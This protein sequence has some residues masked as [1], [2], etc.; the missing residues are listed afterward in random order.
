M[1]KI[2]AADSISPCKH[3]MPFR[4]SSS[5]KRDAIDQDAGELV[6]RERTRRTAC[7]LS[8]RFPSLGD[9]PGAEGRALAVLRP[10][11]G[12]RP[13]RLRCGWHRRRWATTAGLSAVVPTPS[14]SSACG[15]LQRAGTHNWLTVIDQSH[16]FV[17]L[18]ENVPVRSSAAPPTSRPRGLCAGRRSRPNS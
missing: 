16:H 4:A 14:A 12:E 5:S 1:Q 6:E 11:A 13:P 2:M 3:E 15:A 8:S 7:S 18:I 17:F 10:T 9:P